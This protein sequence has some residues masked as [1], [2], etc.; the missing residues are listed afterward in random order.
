MTSSSRSSYPNLPPQPQRMAVCEW[1]KKS[2]TKKKSTQRFCS[3][4]CGQWGR[5]K[6]PTSWNKGLTKETDIKIKQM[7]DSM[8]G[9]IPWNKGKI[10]L[11][12]SWCKGLTKEDHPTL[13]N[14][15]E[16]MLKNTI[17][18]GFKHSEESKKKISE[19]R[20]ERYINGEY[21]TSN[22]TKGRRSYYWS[23]LQNK[24]VFLRSSYELIYCQY[25]DKE[26]IPW[27]YEPK[28]FKLSNGS[29]YS[30]DFYLPTLNEWREVKGYW[31]KSA[32]KKFN[33]FKY[34]YPE[35][36]IKI[37]GAKKIMN[38]KKQIGVF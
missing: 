26:E 20:K 17:T 14:H 34:K 6:N 32:R 33:A 13:V 1:C 24:Y 5:K 11:Q 23:P 4:Y 25:L 9:R 31:Y 36:K 8:Q 21:N 7:S 10:G 2:F 29:S 16:R 22:F 18:L 30:P 35:E 19:T 12:T 28:R 3:S 38:L 27:L 15:S 37:I